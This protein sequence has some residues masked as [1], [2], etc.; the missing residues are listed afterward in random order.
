[1]YIVRPTVHARNAAGS[2]ASRGSSIMVLI[3]CLSQNV[4]MFENQ[5]LNA[6]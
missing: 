2:A 3:E 1:M 6:T 5:L 4:M